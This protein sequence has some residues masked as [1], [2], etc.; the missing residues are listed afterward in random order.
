LEE[1]TDVLLDGEE[2]QGAGG[3]RHCQQT[4]LLQAGVPLETGH[5]HTW[6]ATGRREQ[7][8]ESIC[9]K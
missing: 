3:E 8:V 2:V 6:Q 4:G 7:W 1:H 9:F 5:T